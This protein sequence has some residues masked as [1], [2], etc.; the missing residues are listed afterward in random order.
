[1]EQR[2]PVEIGH[3]V[4]ISLAWYL[5][6][7][8]GGGAVGYLVWQNR[9]GTDGLVLAGEILGAVLLVL[10]ILAPVVVG[11]VLRRL[12]D[13]ATGMTVSALMMLGHI[14]LLSGPL[15]LTTPMVARYLAVRRHNSGSY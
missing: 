11:I 1:V 13:P 15:V 4:A 14:L 9:S 12:D 8:V 7:L 6:V 5:S 2:T 3:Y 10:G